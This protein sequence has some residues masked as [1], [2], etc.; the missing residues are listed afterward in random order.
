MYKH[1]DCLNCGTMQDFRRVRWDA[2]KA[3]IRE[4]TGKRNVEDYWRCTRKG[5]LR[6]QRWTDKHDGGTLPVEFL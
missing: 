6:F 2:E 4:I 5:C 3:A 1:L